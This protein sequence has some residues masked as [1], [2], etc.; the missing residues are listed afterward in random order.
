MEKKTIFRVSSKNDVLV[1]KYFAH[2]YTIHFPNFT[3]S[4]KFCKLLHFFRLIDSF[5][6]LKLIDVQE[7]QDIA[8]LRSML[9][10]SRTVMQTTSLY[11]HWHLYFRARTFEFSAV[12]LPILFWARFAFTYAQL[13][14]LCH[15]VL[16]K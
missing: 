7:V 8:I 12:R 1:K 14:L 16:A 5:A 6:I 9:A 2:S 13:V 4:E 10:H 11:A 3:S 15:D